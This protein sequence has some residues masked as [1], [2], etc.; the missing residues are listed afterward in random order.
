MEKIITEKTMEKIITDKNTQEIKTEDIKPAEIKNEDIKTEEIT[1]VKIPKKRGRKP[2]EKKV[3]EIKIPKKRGRKPKNITKNVDENSI[4]KFDNITDKEKVSSNLIIHLK[5]SSN[6][7]SK[8]NNLIQPYATHKNYS[9]I[10]TDKNIKYKPDISENNNKSLNFLKKYNNVSI[11][12]NLHETFKSF[13]A[14]DNNW[15]IQSDIYCMWCVHP[16]DNI[17]CGIPIKI[18]NNK[19]HLKSCFCSFNC[20]ASYIFDKNDYTKW[21]EYSLLN[22]LAKKV[23][24]VK[25]NI[26]LAPPRETLKIF[27]GILD[28]DEYR[29]KANNITV[30]Y[31]LNIPP[32]IA[33]IAKI[34]EKIVNNDNYVPFKNTLA[35]KI[36][37][38]TYD[39]LSVN[40]NKMN[41]FMDIKIR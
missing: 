17:P 7:I 21:D 31:K 34:E 30:D 5:I 29:E 28:I 13:L 1:P 20:A 22:L 2:K 25:E 6:Y 12:T 8:N 3:D 19:F 36:E 10:N 27:G 4:F 39:D 26:K 41:Q 15:P 9:E 32:M 33:I 35:D 16:F 37:N 18:V 14:Y 11:T 24:K 23:L 38:I 40:D